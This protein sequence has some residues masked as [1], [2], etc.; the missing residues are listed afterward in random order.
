[1]TKT[2]IH[3]NTNEFIWDETDGLITFDGA[4]ALVFWDTAIELFLNT[5]EEVSGKG[6]SKTVYEATGYQM[7]QI[8]KTYYEGRSD[9]EQILVEYRDIY[10]SA[11]WGDFEITYLSLDEKK[12]VV[13]LFNSWENRIFKNGENEHVHVLMPSHWA[14]I[15]GGL[16]K[17]DMWYEVKQTQNEGC[18]YDEI[19]LTKSTITFSKNIHNLARK[20]ELESIAELEEKVQERTEEL[21]GLVKELSSPVIPVLEGILVIPLIGTFNEERLSDL[22][23]RALFELSARKANYILIDV[24]GMTQINEYTIFGLQK[25][26]KAIRLLGSECYIVGVSSGLASHMANANVKMTGILSF[27]SLQQGVEHA[28]GENGYELVKKNNQ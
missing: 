4:S 21:S 19:E 26:I 23:E 27:L 12:V 2:S 9:I 5:I 22:V 7:G 18:S 3:V 17:E 13:R 16:F 1:M 11:G 20:K 14:G 10:K 25:L 6:V 28:I 8:V 15:F 24:T